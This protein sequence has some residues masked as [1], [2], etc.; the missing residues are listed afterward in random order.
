MPDDFV[1]RELTPEEYAAFR[2]YVRDEYYEDLVRNGGREPEDAAAKADAD[3]LTQLPVAGPAED[4]VIRL[5]ERAGERVGYL[6]IGPALMIPDMAWVN[7]IEVEPAFRR[8]GYGR[9]LMAEA[10]RLAADLGY[11][12]LG[13]NVMGGNGGAIA[14][15]ESLG[16][17]VMQQQMQKRL[18]PPSHP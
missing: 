17:T 9:A 3:N 13:L 16:Y 7:D 12:K 18:P 6:W 8:Q 4:H 15:Y 14:L 5:A 10:E 1:L 2:T 11:P